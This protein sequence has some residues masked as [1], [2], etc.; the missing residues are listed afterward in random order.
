MY[1][2]AHYGVLSLFLICFSI[3]LFIVL[4]HVFFT[5]IVYE[6]IDETG[7]YFLIIWIFIA[8]FI[9]GP[10]ISQY[11]DIPIFVGVLFCFFFIFMSFFQS[12]F[13]AVLAEK[14]SMRNIIYTSNLVWSIAFGLMQPHL[15]LI[16]F[17]RWCMG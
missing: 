17:Y 5:H 16:S 3:K 8:C 10:D 2:E 15:K 9:W 4:T 1:D 13:A 11:I 12:I 7:K 14:I 6:N